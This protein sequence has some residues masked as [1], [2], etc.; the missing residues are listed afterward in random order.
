MEYDS[1]ETQVAPTGE[2]SAY[3]ARFRRNLRKFLAI[4]DKT[5][6]EEEDERQPRESRRNRVGRAAPESN[7]HGDALGA[8]PGAPVSPEKPLATECG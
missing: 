2:T 5:E 8:W 3:E 6:H 1:L 4:L 7:R